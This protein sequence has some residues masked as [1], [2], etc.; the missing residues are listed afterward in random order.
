LR[1]RHQSWILSRGGIPHAPT[2]QTRMRQPQMSMND[3]RSPMLI[4]S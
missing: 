2:R 4:S 3:D 1:A